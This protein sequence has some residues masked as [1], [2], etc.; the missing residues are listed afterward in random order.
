MQDR[1]FRIVVAL[2]LAC[3]LF[4]L[5]LQPW[6][7][8]VEVFT[9]DVRFFWRYSLDA[10]RHP[11][12]APRLD[13]TMGDSEDASDLVLI[14][15][16]DPALRRFGKFGTGVWAVRDPFCRLAAVL[17]WAAP[18]AVAF[19]LLFRPAAEETAT[20]VP[21]STPVPAPAPT[22]S[23]TDPDLASR[24]NPWRTGSEDFPSDN[25]TLLAF[26]RYAAQQGE[27]NLAAAFSILAHPPDPDT[28]A[29]PI[30]CAYD[31]QGLEPGQ[32]AHRWSREDILGSDPAS[33][34]EQSGTTLP[35]L[36][37]VAIP[38]AQ[39]LHVPAEY[40]YAA[41]AALPTPVLRDTVQ[42]A[43]I[44]VPRDADGL[45]RRVPLVMGFAYT[46][47]TTGVEHRVFVPSFALLAVLRHWGLTPKD[48]TVDFGHFLEI[49]RHDRVAPWRVPIDANGRM[50]LDFTKRL[51]DFPGISLA[52]LIAIGEHAIAAREGRVQLTDFQKGIVARTARQ[53]RGKL[54]MVGLTAAGTTDIGPCPIDPNTPYVHIHLLAASNILTQRFLQPTG[55]LATATILAGIFVLYT[56]LCRRA[57][58]RQLISDTFLV[59]TLY[60]LLALVLFVVD[61]AILPL[62]T[63][64]LYLATTFCGVLLLRYATEERAKRRIRGMFSTMVSPELLRYLEE[65]PESFSLSG[66]RTE[67]SIM[68]S[69]LAGFTTISEQ[70]P[71]EQL[72]LILNE[73][74]EAMTQIILDSG[75]YLDK[76]E[77]DAI[78]AV[79]GVP[80]STPDHARAACIA[81]LRQ[82]T[83]LDQL[84]PHLRERYGF[85]LRARFGLHSGS[86]IAGNM[87][88]RNH[89]SYTVMGDTVNHASRLEPVNKDYGTTVIIGDITCEL[90]RADMHTRLL[91]RLVVA[92]KTKPQAIY[93]LIGIR[94]E[95]V[96]PERLRQA[97]LYETALRQCWER[98]W[99]GAEARFREALALRP[100]DVAAERQLQRL[101]GYRRNPPPAAWLGEVLR[102]GKD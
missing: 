75:G 45:I 56:F 77:G 9:T 78:M 49:R 59:G 3:F 57:G 66:R 101:D 87:G 5:A 40:R 12:A 53:F 74:F 51:T 41:N 24:L 62:A 76:Y 38:A 94:G 102:A 89:F 33:T 97:E 7:R 19:D 34:S 60:L 54:A 83:A 26:T 42:H 32:T 4:C 67:A 61:I 46:H 70:L 93:E 36:L 86:V 47:P 73:Y 18:S 72:T 11:A 25:L 82:A 16:D 30:I 88:S 13:Q 35:Y 99:D 10:W 14:G 2:S 43:F 98:D 21:E 80:H 63:P 44:N 15:I 64:F 8:R 85:D 1:G 52:Q 37:D 79:W 100:D 17:P 22:A 39:L 48:V 20:D 96:A 58:V 71:P 50:F 90:V 84:R 27:Y 6:L 69:D 55:P 68:F 65:H 81:V 31:L 29:V 23:I 91:D 92:G 95:A 28:P